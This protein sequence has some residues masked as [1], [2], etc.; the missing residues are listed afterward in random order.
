M[1]N[2]NVVKKMTWPA[3]VICSAVIICSS[4]YFSG[5]FDSTNF[6]G[7]LSFLVQNSHTGLVGS[8]GSELAFNDKEKESKEY[9][10][11]ALPNNVQKEKPVENKEIATNNNPRVLFDISSEPIFGNRSNTSIILLL[12]FSVVIILAIIYFIYYIYK[13]KKFQKIKNI[14][15]YH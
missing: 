3:I 2:K 1:K 14:T 11:N 10:S 9:A 7:V 13:R 6:S 4:L 12:I 8:P 15:K 5:I